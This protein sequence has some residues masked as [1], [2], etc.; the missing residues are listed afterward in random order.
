MPAF[1]AYIVFYVEFFSNAHFE[2]SEKEPP[3]HWAREKCQTVE[4]LQVSTEKL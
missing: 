3:K 2:H 4:N 1:Y